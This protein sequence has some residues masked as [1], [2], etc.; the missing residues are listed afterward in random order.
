M[1]WC[2]GWV[3]GVARVPLFRTEG[4]ISG[5]AECAVCGYSTVNSVSMVSGYSS[6]LSLSLL[7]TTTTTTTIPTTLAR[8]TQQC[9]PSFPVAITHQ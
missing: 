4:R 5:L 8:I 1:W 7:T 3:R 2:D 9:T 6:S